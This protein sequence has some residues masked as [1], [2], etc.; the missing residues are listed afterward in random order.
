[1]QVDGTAL[2][3]VTS[4]PEDDREPSLAIAPHMQPKVA[5]CGGRRATLAGTPGPD[6]LVGTLGPDVICGLGGNDIIYGMAG[7]D[8]LVGGP[9][10]DVVR[11]GKGPDRCR[12]EVRVRCRSTVA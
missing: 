5:F 9:G 3:R 11:G 12:G 10:W 4:D 7:A 2:R 8:L 1:V 6:V